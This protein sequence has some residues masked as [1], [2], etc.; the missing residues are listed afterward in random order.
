MITRTVSELA[1]IC[2]ATLEG[3]GSKRVIGPAALDEATAEEISFLG[4]PLYRRELASTRAAAVLVAHDTPCERADL[5]LLRCE[6]PSRSFTRVIETFRPA[7]APLPSGIHESAVVAPGVELGEGVAIGPGCVVEAGSSL[8]AGVVLRA[9][10][11]VGQG[12]RIGAATLVHP[13]VVLYSGVE[14]GERCIL[15]GGSVIGSEGFGFE[16]TPEGWD[17]IP[18]CG[19]VVLEDDVE[20]GGNCVIDRGRFGATRIG[21]CAKLDNLV[22]VGH[23]VQVGPK[24]LLLGQVGIAGSAKLGERVIAA[25]QVGISGH[26]ELAPGVRLAGQSGVT[27]SLDTGDYFGTPARPR[28]EALRTQ[29]AALKI[30]ALLRTVKALESRISELEERA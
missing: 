4:N 9:N 29:A 13:S 23:N 28:T 20:I 6:N 7:E 22:H 21:R 10:V 30:P 15:H 12:V 14:I 11:F 17:K 16:P 24:T 18:Q 8:E 1:E 25:G 3:D 19:T 2:G 26:V 5:A 27:K